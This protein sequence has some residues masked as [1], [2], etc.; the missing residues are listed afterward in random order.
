MAEIGSLKNP[1]KVNNIGSEQFQHS[2]KYVVL[3]FIKYLNIG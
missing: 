1:I 2:E 3:V